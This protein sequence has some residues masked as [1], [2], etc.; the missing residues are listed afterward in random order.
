MAYR[1]IDRLTDKQV[2]ELHAL[3]KQEWW[4]NHRQPEDI[5]RML[6]SGGVIIALEDSATGELAAFARVLTDNVYRAHLFDVIVCESHRGQGLG[7]M[8]VDAVV[9]H[10]VIGKVEKI[11]LS[12]RTELVPFYER[13]GFTTE[14]GPDIHVMVRTPPKTN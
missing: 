14:L 12:C 3:Y 5:R 4:T 2:E 9:N 8:I 13:W 10:P 1:L 7:K 6:A 11:I